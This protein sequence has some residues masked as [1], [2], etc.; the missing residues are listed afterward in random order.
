LANEEV[1]IKQSAITG[2]P[3]HIITGFL[4]VGKTTAIFYLLNHKPAN[5]NWAV[6][7]DARKL[8]DTRYTSHEIFN[9]QLAIAD[10]VVANKADLYQQED[11]T[12]LKAYLKRQAKAETALIFT[13]QGNIPAAVLGNI[14]T[15]NARQ[16]L[17]EA[18]NSP[19]P[20][21]TT[22]PAGNYVKAANQGEGYHSVG[23]RFAS[24]SVFDRHKLFLFLSALAAE[25]MKAVFITQ[26]GIFAYNL[27]TD[28]LTEWEQDDCMDSRIE[29]I[30]RQVE[31][32]WE[33]QLLDCLV[34]DT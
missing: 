17:F 23:W 20:E 16:K 22:L 12:A 14:T 9:Q 34:A 11:K 8:S 21:E 3:T 31:D 26:T 1:A 30:A 6:L 4:G 13:E 7:V 15:T 29:I 25:R 33:E 28:A 24:D 2:V 27:T 5:E 32:T 18:I 10:I 19:P